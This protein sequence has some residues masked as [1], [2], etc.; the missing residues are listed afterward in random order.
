M[1][2]LL[3]KAGVLALVLSASG[4]SLADNNFGVGV[5]AGTLGLGVEGTW[6]PLPYLDVRIGANTYHYNTTRS[7]AGIDYDAALNLETVYGTANFR[8]P[9]SPFRV[10]AGIYSNGNELLL[11]SAEAGNIEI[12]GVVFTPAEYGS[13]T[14]TTSFSGTA[15]YL[16]FGYD[17]SFA[18][19]I[20]I[21]LDFGVLWQGDPSVTVNATG[22]LANDPSFQAALETERLEL[23]DEVSDF[24]AWP[25]LSLGFVYSF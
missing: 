12:G 8:F 14:S 2:S 18:N 25:V 19:K 20:G 15:P 1:K 11:T 4:T 24:K 7:E 3:F 16:G 9:L 21:N 22:L 10:T 23:E 6:R 13:V 17:F 5:K